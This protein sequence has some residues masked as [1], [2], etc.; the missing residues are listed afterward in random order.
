MAPITRPPFINGTAPM[1]GKASPFSTAGAAAQKAEPFCAISPN[2]FV[3]RR[4]ATAATAF[5]RDVSVPTKALEQGG[6]E[7]PRIYFDG[8]FDRAGM[9]DMVTVSGQG[10]LAGYPGRKSFGIMH[11]GGFAFRKDEYLLVTLKDNPRAI[12]VADLNG[13]GRSDLSLRHTSRLEVF[14]SK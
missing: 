10:R 6:S 11:S 1:L 3:A 9:L 12:D 8:D 4:N 14:L 5:A 2:S 7:V 13:D